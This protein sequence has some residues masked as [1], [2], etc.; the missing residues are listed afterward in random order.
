[1]R[2]LRFLQVVS[3]SATSGAERHTVALARR[4]RSE[5]HHVEVVSPPID[6][7]RDE[8]KNEDIPVHQLDMRKASGFAA[9]RYMVS[10]A[11]RQ[12]FD[13]VH[14]HLSRAAYLSLVATAFAGTPLVCS[15]HVKT[16]YFVYRMAARGS[17][18]MVAVSNYIEGLLTN[19]GVPA[20]YIDVV[21]NGTDFHDVSYPSSTDVFDEFG[22][23]KERK[24]VGLVGRVAEEKGHLIAVNA[25][26]QV[27]TE[28][29]DAH[30][31]FVGRDQGEFSDFLKKEV[32]RRD[33][34]RRVTFTGNRDDVARLLD[35]MD[36]SILPSSAEACPLAVIESMARERPVVG[37]NIG[38][39]DELVIHEKTGLLVDQ[40]AEAFSGGMN[41]LLNHEAERKEMGTNALQLIH[42]RFTFEQMMERMEAVYDRAIRKA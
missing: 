16:N 27:L 24:L 36:F 7:I 22:I 32:S 29:P 38:G 20:N 42:E 23:P 30:I 8:L 12:K 21:H 6:W 10:L 33:L 41:Y 31:M 15:V 4:L 13:L 2:S 39:V 40:T 34:D 3:S 26:P 17:N 37:A 11:R 28:S 9:M 5:G 1:M 25:L 18:R 19:A 35:A 14:A